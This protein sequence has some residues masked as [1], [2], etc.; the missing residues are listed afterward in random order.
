VHRVSRYVGRYNEAFIFKNN[1]ISIHFQEQFYLNSFSRTVLSQFY[2][3]IFSLI[4][5][6]AFLWSLWLVFCTPM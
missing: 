2:E 5:S 6:I 3:Y 4:N 1:F